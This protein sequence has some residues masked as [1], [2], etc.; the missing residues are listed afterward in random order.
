MKF[1]I[2]KQL[3]DYT[4]VG[5]EDVVLKTTLPEEY[6][7][8]DLSCLE[9]PILR[10]NPNYEI[11]TLESSKI[12]IRMECFIESI[13]DGF[14]RIRIINNVLAVLSYFQP[15]PLTLEECKATNYDY[16]GYGSFFDWIPIIEEK[17]GN[18]I[19]LNCNPESIQYKKV[20]LVSCDDHDR[21]GF[22]ISKYNVEEIV[23]KLLQLE[24]EQGTTTTEYEKG[25]DAFYNRP[26][27]LM[28]TEEEMEIYY[29]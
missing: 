5:D 6:E 9:N 20:I 19:L 16:N 15:P 23:S 8:P 1:T 18:M 2:D 3:D 13:L 14:Y 24:T 21:L 17:D 11:I 10:E 28:M 25:W 7:V 4:V 29:G 12:K 22:Y 26:I 27:K